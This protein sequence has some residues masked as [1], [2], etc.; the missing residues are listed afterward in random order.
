[1]PSINVVSKPGNAGYIAKV[2]VN[3]DGDVRL[4]KSDS[5]ATADHQFARVEVAW[6]GTDR[7]KISLKG[8]GPALI[9]QA[10]L[11]GAGQNVILDLIADQGDDE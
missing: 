7:I 9:R 4:T 10:Y 1:M 8:A 3:P 6:Y 5:A 11:P 2:D